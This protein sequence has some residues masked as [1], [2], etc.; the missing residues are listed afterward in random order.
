M[1]KKTT[2]KTG[3]YH[4]LDCAKA[5][6]ILPIVAFAPSMKKSRQFLKRQITSYYYYK[7]TFEH[8]HLPE[9]KIPVIS[10]VPWTTP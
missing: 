1:V 5:L 6:T 7:N 4:Y 9:K 2:I 10:R 8:T 3:R